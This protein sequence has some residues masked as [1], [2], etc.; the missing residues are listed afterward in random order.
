ML[1]VAVEMRRGGY[2]LCRVYSYNVQPRSATR[3]E[4]TYFFACCNDSI[5]ELNCHEQTLQ[6]PR[7]QE[8]WHICSEHIGHYNCN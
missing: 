3:P 2:G 6:N 7:R 4:E 1:V 8:G 5:D